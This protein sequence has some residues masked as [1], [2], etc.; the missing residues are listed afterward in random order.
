VNKI[1][2]IQT[3][4]AGDLILTLPLIQEAKRLLHCSVL[5]VL[6]IPST[7]ALVAGHPDISHLII[8]DKKQRRPSLPSLIRRLRSAKYDICISPHRSLRSALLS[9][10][11]GAER[12]VSFDNSAGRILYTHLAPY[13]QKAHEIVRNLSLLEPLVEGIDYSCHP[14]LFPSDE[15]EAAA[16]SVRYK[17]DQGRPYICLAAGSVWATKRWL[18]EGFIAVSKALLETHDVVFI[19][20]NEDR[21]L[22]EAIVRDVDDPRCVSSSG[23]LSFPGTAALIRD[24]QLLISNDSAPVHLASAMRTPV[25]EIYGATIPGFGFTPFGVSHE[26]VQRNGLACRPCGIHG[27]RVCPIKTFECM[28]SITPDDVLAAARRL[29]RPTCR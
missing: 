22:T 13:R 16:Q 4:Y 3:A 19:G 1:L 29:L 28:K 25:I 18:K 7:Q 8:Y 24:A 27:G 14:L 9:Y 21:D 15:E 10:G 26:I 2:I 12:R 20:G 23:Q 11:T 6:C 17:T 5:D